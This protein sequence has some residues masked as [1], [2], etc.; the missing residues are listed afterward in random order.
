MAEVELYGDRPPISP[1][2]M[3][4]LDGRRQAPSTGCGTARG[5]AIVSHGFLPLMGGAE[6]H[7]AIGASG[8]ARLS[9]VRVYA[10]DLCLVGQRQTLVT[11]QSLNMKV[12]GVT[13][14]VEYLPSIRLLRE[15]FILPLPLFVRLSRYAPGVVWTSHPSAS[16]LASGLYARL[17]GA[18]WIVSYHADLSQDRL[19]TR[20]FTWLEAWWLR[21]ADLVEVSSLKYAS[22][23]E[24]R[25][26][27]RSRLLIIQPVTP[28]TRLGTG[29]LRERQ[30][31]PA[32]PGPDQPFLFVGA[33]DA[34]HDY[35][36]PEDLIHATSQLRSS[37]VPVSVA[38]VGDGDRRS[39]FET[40][41]KTL[42]LSGAVQFLGRVEDEVLV[43]LY[44]SAWGLVVTS[45]DE[46]EGYGIVILE[47]LSHGCPVLCSD[48]VPGV[49]RYANGMG[50][51]T[52][53]AGDVDDLA[54]KMAD[55]WLSPRQREALVTETGAL[56]IREENARSLNC[57]VRAVLGESRD[58]MAPSQASRS[59][60]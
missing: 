7:M 42:G 56:D 54:Q 34:S 20:V 10:S 26:V 40:L 44:R 15:K 4:D 16:A 14:D 47:A 38:I 1:P 25:G 31:R 51:T 50:A 37:G 28:E 55:L 21:C 36:H 41:S 48:L 2:E 53:R 13:I 29:P 43:R 8:V 3:R 58:T 33:L 11:H 32:K 59:V 23:L 60:S 6:T 39:S 46:S 45:S 35:K 5:V 22:R 17:R 27:K 9:P 18:R 30:D 57:M 12:E 19:L 49:E 52:F 24:A